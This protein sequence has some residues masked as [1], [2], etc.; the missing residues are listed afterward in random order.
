MIIQQPA[1]QLPP[2]AIKTLLK[3]GMRKPGRIRP[4]QEADQR[5]ELLPAAQQTQPHRIRRAAKPG[6]ARY[7][8]PAGRTSSPEA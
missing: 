3:L 2:V 1:Q 6:A 5:L 8:R 4:V 7:Q